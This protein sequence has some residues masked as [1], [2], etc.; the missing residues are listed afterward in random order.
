VGTDS[1]ASPLRA[2]RFAEHMELQLMVRAGL[3]PL[4]AITVATHNPA[5]VLRDDKDYGTLEP[6]KKA[7]FIVLDKDPSKNIANTHT[8]VAVWKDGKKISDGPLA[9]KQ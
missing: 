3:T 8:I 6:G 4:E 2:Q 7:N 9:Q 5:I 1:G